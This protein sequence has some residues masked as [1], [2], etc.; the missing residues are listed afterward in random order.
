MSDEGEQAA[1]PPEAQTVLDFWY[2]ECD[3]EQ[4]FK[5]NAAFDATIRTRFATLHDQACAGALDG[6]AATPRGCLAL[7]LILDQFSRNLFR[8]DGRA[9]AFD[10]K[11]VDLVRQALARDDDRTLAEKERMFLYMPLMHSED[12]DDQRLC[13]D[14]M[15]DFDDDGPHDFAKRHLEIIE[16]FGRFPHRNAVLGRAST[17]EEELFLQQ[18]GSSF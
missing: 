3:A 15:S 8:D 16:R 5:K 17:D 18:P 6:W 2:V 4:W 11:T 14:K 10:Q 13:V 9:F 12:L 7:I 1:L